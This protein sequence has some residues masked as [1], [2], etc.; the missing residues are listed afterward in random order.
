M[1][2]QRV[3]RCGECPHVP[4]WSLDGFASADQQITAIG[5]CDITGSIVQA[6][7]PT[8]LYRINEEHPEERIQ[9]IQQGSPEQDGSGLAPIPYRAMVPGTL[10]VV[11]SPS[12]D[13][14]FVVGDHITLLS[15]GAIMCQEAHGW[16]ESEEI[17]EAA[18]GM[19]VVHDIEQAKKMISDLENQAEALRKRYGLTPTTSSRP[20]S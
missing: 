8:C 1:P 10:Y 17:P 18:E 15:D 13:G 20:G 2:K 11:S 7:Q 5:R 12:K 19:T 14:T 6:R 4:C 3:T 16:I 9:D